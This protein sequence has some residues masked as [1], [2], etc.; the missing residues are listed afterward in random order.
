MSGVVKGLAPRFEEFISKRSM[1]IQAAKDLPED[2]SS[3]N[4]LFRNLNLCT[5]STELQPLTWILLIGIVNIEAMGYLGQNKKWIWWTLNKDWEGTQSQEEKT[6]KTIEEVYF[7]FQYNF[8][9]NYNLS[10]TQPL[11][12]VTDAH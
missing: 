5:I 6:F 10:W 8:G 12:A 9:D 1:S 11:N 4:V 3:L 2:V 7:W